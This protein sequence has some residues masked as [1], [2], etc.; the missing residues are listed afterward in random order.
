MP[1]TVSAW[2]GRFQ[3]II[4]LSTVSG[5]HFTFELTFTVQ[6]N[7]ANV[8]KLQSISFYEKVADYDFRHVFFWPRSISNPEMVQGQYAHSFSL[9]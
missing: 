4:M 9:E 5:F 6:K 8:C 7:Q 1:V 2:P 3:W